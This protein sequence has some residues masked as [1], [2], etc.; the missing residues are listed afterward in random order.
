MTVKDLRD[1]D[2]ESLSPVL[3]TRNSKQVTEVGV[4]GG[5]SNRIPSQTLAGYRIVT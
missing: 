3:E 5:N 2:G 4:S 1:S